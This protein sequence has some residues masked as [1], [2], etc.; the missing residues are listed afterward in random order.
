MRAK[1]MR[2]ILLNKGYRIGSNYDKEEQTVRGFVEA[3]KD[4]WMVWGK[5]FDCSQNFPEAQEKSIEDAIKRVSG[6]LV[7]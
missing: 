1:E 7:E 6:K 5:K 3:P 4:K 2:E